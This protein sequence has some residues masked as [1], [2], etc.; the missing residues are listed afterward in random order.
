MSSQV[1]ICKTILFAEVEIKKLVSHLIMCG[2]TAVIGVKH[3]VNVLIE[4][5]ERMEYRGYDSAGVACVVE[6]SKKGPASLKIVKK[7][8]K[9]CVCMC[10]GVLVNE[11][12]LCLNVCSY[13]S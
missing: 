8:G 9:V 13:F 7:K 1:F 5:L 10:V 11:S 12:V 6:T 2:I 3:A 4:G